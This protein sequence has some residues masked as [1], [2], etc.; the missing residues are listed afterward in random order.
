MVEGPDLIAGIIG[1]GNLF[2][3]VDAAVEQS[4]QQGAGS[5][6]LGPGIIFSGPMQAE[7]V[8]VTAVGGNGVVGL[9]NS[10]ELNLEISPN[11]EKKIMGEEG[12]DCE[13]FEGGIVEKEGVDGVLNVFENF[14]M[15]GPV[16]LILSCVRLGL[17][18]LIE[19]GELI[20]VEGLIGLF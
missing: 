17:I 6:G 1:P 10:N 11:L 15:D 9:A 8:G 3:P 16:A 5:S 2:S 18:G 4:G 13:E 20:I 19:R 12:E 7:S 14:P